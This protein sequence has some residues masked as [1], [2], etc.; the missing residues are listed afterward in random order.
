MRSVSQKHQAAKER[1][2]SSSNP[3]S[4]GVTAT[5]NGVQLVVESPFK[6]QNKGLAMSKNSKM[7]K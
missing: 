4:A 7:R 3:P 6:S 2:T 1:P 5:H